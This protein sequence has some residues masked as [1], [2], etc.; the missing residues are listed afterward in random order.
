MWVAL[1]SFSFIVLGVAFIV[2]KMPG[3]YAPV[4]LYLLGIFNV[5]KQFRPPTLFEIEQNE[6]NT[7]IGDVLA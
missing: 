2:F 7:S 4:V 5:V 1:Y 6:E 3:I